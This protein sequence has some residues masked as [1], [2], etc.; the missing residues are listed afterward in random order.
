VKAKNLGCSREPYGIGYQ[1]STID[2][3][4]TSRL[5]WLIEAVFWEWR[6]KRFSRRLEAILVREVGP[7]VLLL[8][9]KS[10]QIH[11][12]NQTASFI[13][14]RLVVPASAEEIAASVANE[15]DV[16][17][18]LALQEVVE[19]LDKLHALKLIVEAR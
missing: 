3:L 16:E 6:V 8:D 11:Q 18:Q 14:G 15:F 9:T 1:C 12:L 19:T 7:E 10:D 4:A 2:D 17:E 5:K 13:W